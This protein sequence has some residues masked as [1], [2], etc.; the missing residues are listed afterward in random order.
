MIGM[1]PKEASKV[2]EINSINKINSI[3]IKEFSK[4]NMKR[5][6][7]KNNSYGLL[8]PKLILIGKQTLMRNY[9]KK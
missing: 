4:I 9:I 3:K 5:N 1:S 2:T 8:N 7:I 6:Y